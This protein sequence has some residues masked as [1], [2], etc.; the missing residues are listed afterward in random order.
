MLLR[1]Q[2]Y[3][4]LCKILYGQKPKYKLIVQNKPGLINETPLSDLLLRIHLYRVSLG[5][6]RPNSDVTA[7]LRHSNIKS[8]THG[9]IVSPEDV[10]RRLGTVGDDAGQVHGAA[11][12]QVDVRAP[13]DGRA[14]LWQRNEDV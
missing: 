4:L 6:K 9:V 11:L 7:S 8:V 12:L 10:R 14:R 1:S 2:C 5:L 3:G 13:D